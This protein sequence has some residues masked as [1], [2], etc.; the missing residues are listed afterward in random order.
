MM[1]NIQFF[2]NIAIAGGL[3]F[4]FAFGPSAYSLDAR[5]SL[6]HPNVLTA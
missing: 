3:L 5:S 4:V 2:R 6:G 1:Q